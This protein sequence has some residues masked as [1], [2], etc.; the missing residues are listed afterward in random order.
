MKPVYQTIFGPQGNCL[1]ACLASLLEIDLGDVPDEV[2]RTTPGLKA[3][4]RS[5]DLEPKFQT[6]R[7]PPP[8]GYS[9]AIQQVQDRDV[10]AVIVHDRLIVHDPSLQS[11]T[12][13]DDPVVLWIS[14][15]AA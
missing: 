9:I 5:R 6:H 7:F 11:V 15:V 12:S 14:L 2:V 10:H 3:W 1:S 8:D 4:L 13:F